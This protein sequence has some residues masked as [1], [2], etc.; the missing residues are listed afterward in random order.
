MPTIAIVDGV[1]LMMYFNDHAPAHLHALFAEHRA[2]LD[3]DTLTV[4]S[5]YLPRAKLGTVVRWATPRR[6]ELMR[7]W[8]LI[9]AHLPAGMVK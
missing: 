4:T 7:A 8:D 1:R 5:G 9:Q 2:V 3:I 6:S